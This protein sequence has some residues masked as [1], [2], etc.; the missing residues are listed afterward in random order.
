MLYRQVGQNATLC[1]K[2]PRNRTVISDRVLDLLV[3]E[4]R[5]GGGLR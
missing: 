5:E 3:T 1:Y 2:C 4:K